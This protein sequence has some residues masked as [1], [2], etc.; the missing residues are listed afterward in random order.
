MSQILILV[1]KECETCI[2]STFD[3]S[4]KSKIII[5]CDAKGKAL[6]YG[7]YVP[8]SEYHKKSEIERAFRG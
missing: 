3:E 1:G 7:S 8:C 5:K 4:D 2:Y 6:I